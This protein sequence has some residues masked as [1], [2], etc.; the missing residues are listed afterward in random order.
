[1]QLITQHRGL[2]SILFRLSSCQE[3]SIVVELSRQSMMSAEDN[4][5][6]IC[7]GVGRANDVNTICNLISITTTFFE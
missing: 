7:R 2:P 5:T 4:D 6:A 3:L 1:K